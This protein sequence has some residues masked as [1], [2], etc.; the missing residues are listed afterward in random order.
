MLSCVGP[1]GPPGAPGTDGIDGVNG[2]PGEPT[3]TNAPDVFTSGSRIKALTTIATTTSNDG[4]K[5]EVRNFAGWFDSVRNETCWPRTTSEGKTRC[6]P[7]GVG[8]GS[9]TYF[10]DAACTQPLGYQV[11]QAP[12]CPSDP[13]TPDAKYVLEFTTSGCIALVRIRTAG[14]R[15]P[16]GLRYYKSGMSCTAQTPPPS[17]ALYEPQADV[18]LTEFE[19]MTVE[20]RTE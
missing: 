16:S 15:L 18:S 20:T 9:G 11:T 17:V 14:P 4:A 12:T 10:L 19:E 7:V 5:R 3:G 1:E 8:V 2:D 13:P 6:I